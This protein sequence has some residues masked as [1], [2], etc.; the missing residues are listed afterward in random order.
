MRFAAFVFAL[1][2]FAYGTM[3]TLLVFRSGYYVAAPI[4]L[5]IAGALL[6]QS[7]ALIRERPAARKYGIINSV[8]IALGSAGL[9]GIILWDIPPNQWTSSI[10][11]IPI[12]FALITTVM[13]A[14]SATAVILWKSRR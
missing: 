11:I 8:V 12:T 3:I 6:H 2:G 1:A 13:I 4:A 9:L 5:L 14:F 10:A 7:Y